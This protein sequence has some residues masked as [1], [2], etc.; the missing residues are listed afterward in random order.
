[1]DT[2]LSCEKTGEHE[3]LL[4]DLN[5]KDDLKNNE[6]FD[7]KKSSKENFFYLGNE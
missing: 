3:V 6:G 4:E 7:L 2:S 1:M 5:S